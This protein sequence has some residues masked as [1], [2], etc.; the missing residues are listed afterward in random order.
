MVYI[1]NHAEDKLIF[2]DLTFVPVLEG[3]ADQ[4]PNVKGI[5]IMTDAAHMP[6]T[7]LKNVHCYEDLIDGQNGDFNWV[8]VDERAPC[9]H[10]YASGTA[11]SKGVC[12]TH[13]SNVLHTLVGNAS[14][15][16]GLK[17]TDSISPSCRCSMPMLGVFFS[18]PAAGSKIVN[19]G[20]NMDG[21]YLSAFDR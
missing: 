11:Q 9:G 4:I 7:G 3:I 6:D 8:E 19:P 1:I 17:S 10:C 15:V 18:A 21:E 2:T 12:Y 20:P 13:R 5:I 14:D 16:M